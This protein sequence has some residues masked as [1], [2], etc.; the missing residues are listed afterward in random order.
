MLPDQS[1]NDVP[2]HSLAGPT[3]QTSPKTIV[4]GGALT[5]RQP[6]FRRTGNLVP[7]VSPLVW[8]AL[9][10]CSGSHPA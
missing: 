3:Q 1:V 7:N 2:D 8:G 9:V 6:A 5:G 10:A 4:I